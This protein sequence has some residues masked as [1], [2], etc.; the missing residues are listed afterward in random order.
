MPHK[1][2]MKNEDAEGT[3]LEYVLKTL[4]EL[5]RNG[6]ATR[7]DLQTLRNEVENIRDDVEGGE[8]GYKEKPDAMTTLGFKK[9]SK[10]EKE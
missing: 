2:M 5:I 7:E 6:S 1:M 8:T 3:P 10:G 4:D 9:K